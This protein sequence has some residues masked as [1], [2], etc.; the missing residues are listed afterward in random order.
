[1]FSEEAAR[2]ISESR[3]QM[4]F[5]AVTTDWNPDPQSLFTVRQGVLSRTPTRRPT[6]LLREHWL[7][8]VVQW[9]ESVQSYLAMYGPST[10]D[11]WMTF[12]IV[13]ESISSPF[14]P[15]ES[16]AARDAIS[17]NSIDDVSFSRPPNAPKAVLLAPTI[18][19]PR[20]N[21]DIFQLRTKT[22]SRYKTKQVT[23]TRK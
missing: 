14:T 18:K 3:R 4:S 20:S 6:C 2:A 15:A 23:S 10:P 21:D 17:P 16:R 7:Y 8:L 19:T 1:M 22:N 5:A 13:T 11:T 9:I 12:P